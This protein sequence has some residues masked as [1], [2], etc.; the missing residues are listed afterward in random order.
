MRCGFFPGARWRVCAPVR[1]RRGG[2]GMFFFQPAVRRPRPQT[3]RFDQLPTSC[4]DICT[5]RGV[6]ARPA[7]FPAKI[8]QKLYALLSTYV[9]LTCRAC[10]HY[11]V[12]SLYIHNIH[13][14]NVYFAVW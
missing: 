4:V 5:C 13:R 2:R 9:F 11:S 7:P 3:R 8:H 12:S 10:A 14:Y 1:V 6:A